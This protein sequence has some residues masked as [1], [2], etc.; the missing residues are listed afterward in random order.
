MLNIN[1]EKLT[2][3]ALLIAIERAVANLAKMQK[4]M[5]IH[6]SSVK[7]VFKQ[8]FLWLFF[9]GLLTKNSVKQKTFLNLTLEAVGRAVHT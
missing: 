2:K 4:F 7:K 9:D 8:N 6:P 3:N 1:C 5:P